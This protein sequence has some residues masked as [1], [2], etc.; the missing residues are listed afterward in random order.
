MPVSKATSRRVLSTCMV[1]G[2][3]IFML[4]CCWFC[5]AIAS[6]SGIRGMG[7][8]TPAAV[9]AGVRQDRINMAITSG[10]GL[11]GLGVAVWGVA[12]WPRR[13]GGNVC[14]ACGYDRVGLDPDRC[15]PE[16]GGR[17]SVEHV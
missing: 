4:T 12:L 6:L 8:P 11:V 13:R 5:A 9:A 15:C 17:V 7:N 16:C 3:L 14:Q 1:I 10:L 2:G